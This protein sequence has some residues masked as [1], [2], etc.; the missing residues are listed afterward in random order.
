MTTHPAL[1][2]GVDRPLHAH[3]HGRLERPEAVPGAASPCMTMR[4]APAARE[5]EPVDGC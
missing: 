2:D 5:M 4:P 1:T 3:G